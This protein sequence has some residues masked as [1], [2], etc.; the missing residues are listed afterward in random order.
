[1]EKDKKKNVEIVIL[2]LIIIGLVGAI[3]YLNTNKNL[4]DNVDESDSKDTTEITNSTDTDEYVHYTSAEI[5]YYNDGAKSIN[6][7][8]QDGKLVDTT[9]AV[10]IEGINGKVKYFTYGYECEGG[11][12]ILAITENNQLYVAY[13][14]PYSEYKKIITFEQLTTSLNVV[15]V[16]QHIYLGWHTCNSANLAVVTSNGE[17]Y[18]VASNDDSYYIYDDIDYSEFEYELGDVIIYADYTIQVDTYSA[19]VDELSKKSGRSEVK[20]NNQDLVIKNIYEV[21]SELYYILASDNKLYKLEVNVVDDKP[22]SFSLSLA[23][24]KI[25]SNTLLTNKGYSYDSDGK[26]T[27][28]I[29]FEDGTTKTLNDISQLYITK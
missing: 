23:S 5:E 16:T 2:L 24:E 21:D 26:L 10:S 4:K 6:L 9:N 14:F 20:Y 25:V 13:A 18:S 12:S 28:I 15:D 8:I 1:M 27:E 11:A 7:Q 29:T 17:I 22:K 19:S 3:I